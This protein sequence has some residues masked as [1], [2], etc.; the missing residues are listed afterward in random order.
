MTKGK[1]KKLTETQAKTPLS[2][3][4]LMLTELTPKVFHQSESDLFPKN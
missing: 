4:G 3:K 2:I 1:H